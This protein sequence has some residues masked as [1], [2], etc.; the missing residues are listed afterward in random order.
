MSVFKAIEDYKKYNG[1]LLIRRTTY[2]SDGGIYQCRA[3]E[4]DQIQ[5]ADIIVDVHGRC[6]TV[7][8]CYSVEW[9]KRVETVVYWG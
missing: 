6:Q 1:T 4:K 9:A 8:F 2:P 3:G 5:K 7:L